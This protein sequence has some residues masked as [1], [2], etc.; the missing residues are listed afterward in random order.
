MPRILLERIRKI[1]RS[2]LF[3]AGLVLFTVTFT[4]AVV[5][6][7]HPLIPRWDSGRGDLLIVL[8]GS[9]LGPDPGGGEMALLGPSSYI[10]AVH[11][12]RLW[13]EHGHER[14]LIVGGDGA[15]AAMRRFL[16]VYGVPAARIEIET[17]SKT[18]RENALAV[19]TRIASWTEKP[20]WI[21]LL[22]SD[23]H[24]RR[25]AGCFRQA[26]VSV[27]LAP[28]PDILK[29]GNSYRERWTC[30]WQLADEYMSLVYYGYKGW[31]AS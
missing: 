22:T 26:G 25:A 16:I 18:T 4:P 20:Q 8:A 3:L 11:A 5:W 29:R 24:V 14:V 9:V 31:L 15:S 2:I 12:V 30:L 10:R 17:D 7:V 28:S 27:H 13:R 21:A 23:Y 6:A 19:A 1:V